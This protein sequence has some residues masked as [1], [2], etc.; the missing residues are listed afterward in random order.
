MLNK[1]DILFIVTGDDTRKGFVDGNS[2]RNGGTGASGTEQSCILIAEKLSEKNFNCYISSNSGP[3]GSNV[4]GVN[5]VNYNL[6]GCTVTCFE[7][8]VCVP[9]LSRFINLPNVNNLIIWMHCQTIEN[10]VYF[11][12]L[13][14]SKNIKSVQFVHLSGWTMDYINAEQKMFLKDVHVTQKIIENPLMTDIFDSYNCDNKRSESFVFHP[15]YERGGEMSKAIFEKL[16]WPNGEFH[17]M[18]Y[19]SNDE[20]LCNGDSR[21]INHCIC[22]KSTLKSILDVTEYFVYP[23]ISHHSNRI[24]KDTFGCCIAEAL[25]TKNIVITFN[26]VGA[27]PEIY[28]DFVIF[29]DLPD[30]VKNSDSITNF[31]T[32]LSAAEKSQIYNENM[33]MKFVEKIQF[34]ENNPNT[35]E[36]IKQR[37]YE[38]A[39]KKFEL[40]C[41]SNKWNE[42]L[43][44]V[45]NKSYPISFDK[46]VYDH[47]VLLSKMH[48]IPSNH[49]DYLWKLKNSGFEPKVIYDIGACVLHWTNEAKQIWPNAEIFVFDAIEEYEF[50][51]RKSKH[52]FNIGMLSNED[53]KQKKYFYSLTHPGGSSYYREIGHPHSFTI[54]NS[55]MNK[56]SITLDT[57]VANR[58]FPLPDLIKIDVQGSEFDIIQGATK[59]MQNAKHLIVEMQHVEY[60]ENAP[61]VETT[62][63]F[64]ESLGF[65]CVAPLF[66]DNGPD[67]DYGFMRRT[68]TT[69]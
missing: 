4:N 30:A 68:T 41:L 25:I 8:I 66:Q 3:H 58:E 64:I 11:H 23:L 14:I 2:I 48:C 57:V 19:Y 12:D 53:G 15:C 35:K 65:E 29:I 50:L 31:S 60:N 42:L 22:D 7:F 6:D 18:N 47:A 45:I 61:K 62:L 28:K 46:N 59:T 51:Y 43:T 67:G 49:I 69:G 24:H 27:V 16:N 1:Y 10:D 63:P 9:W 5:Y 34:L 44:N 13:I 32:H 56:S 36:I 52:E 20:N 26:D 55:F 21:I 38:F 17:F 40:G 33:V 54:F 39:R 37:G